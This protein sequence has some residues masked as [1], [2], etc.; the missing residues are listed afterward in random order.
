MKHFE[1]FFNE[2]K[3]Y[4]EILKQY[5]ENGKVFEDSNFHPIKEITESKF[6]FDKQ[7]YTWRRID[8]FYP[9]P[10]FKK[11]SISDTYIQQ[12][13]LK[14]SYFIAALIRIA[15]QPK[16]IE[17]LFDI[18]TKQNRND[19]I[20]L[21]CGA[22]IVYFHIFGRKT[23]VLIDTLIPFQR[24]SRTPIFSHP[25]DNKYSAWFC[26]VEKAYAKLQGS[27]S[28]ITTGTFSQAIYHLFGYYPCQ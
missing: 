28:S 9:V 20:D 21:K 17:K 25:T 10:I 1:D 8:G 7:E 14:D 16:L 27:Y 19:S 13:E 4:S 23:P 24:G 3:Q 12:G 11:E 5:K 2:A 15:K 26:L 6:S 22:V 18:R